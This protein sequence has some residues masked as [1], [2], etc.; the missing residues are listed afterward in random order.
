MS[1]TSAPR[2][3]NMFM[4]RAAAAAWVAY[5]VL[6]GRLP[7][8]LPPNARLVAIIA[9]GLVILLPLT[10]AEAWWLRMPPLTLKAWGLAAAAALLPGALS[11]LSYAYAQRELGVARTGLMMCTAPLWAALLGWLLLGEP[12]QLHHAIGAALILPS[13]ALATWR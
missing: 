6:L 2:R 7:S 10:A 1:S 5:S 4:S 8:V 13:I 3:V 11:H 9:G 12:P